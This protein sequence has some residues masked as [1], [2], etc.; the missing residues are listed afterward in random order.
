MLARC[1]GA[2]EPRPGA[3]EETPVADTSII[4]AQEA[5]SA[6]IMGQPGVVGTAVGLCDGGPCIKVYLANASPELRARIPAT[7]R[8]FVVDPEVT[9]E[10]RARGGG[11]PR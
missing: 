3:P 4:A 10:L 5:L 8:G 2:P 9:G 11:G 1:G 6:E 7:Y